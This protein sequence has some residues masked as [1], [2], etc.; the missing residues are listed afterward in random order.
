MD[1]ARF[2]QRGKDHEL[3]NEAAQRRN[4]HQAEQAD[5]HANTQHRR[6]AGEPVVVFD[7]F[8]E[9]QIAQ[10][11]DNGKGA[12]VH[13]QIDQQVV[14]Q[15]LQ[16]PLPLEAWVD[17][18]IRRGI[19]DNQQGRNSHQHITGVG[20]RGIGQKAFHIRLRIGGQVAIRGGYRGDNAKSHAKGEIDV[21]ERPAR[22]TDEGQ[23]EA[24]QQREG[25]S[26]RC[27][28]QET[29]HF[30]RRAFKGVRT[31][32]MERDQRQLERQTGQH[33]HDPQHNGAYHRVRQTRSRPDHQ[34]QPRR[35]LGQFGR[36]K[37]A[38]Q[39]ADPVQHHASRS[40]AVDNVLERRL[41]AET[42]ALQKTDQDV[43]GHTRH[44]DAQEQDQ[45]VVRTDHQRHPHHRSQQ[46]RVEIGAV[47]RIGN[48]A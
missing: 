20:N 5:G 17:G 21:R 10:D 47:I 11:G 9:D 25:G 39:Q 48:T 29:G 36:S 35:Q 13:K 38:G 26:L 45:K 31:P 32:E 18:R 40:A 6:L 19:R 34:I 33:H 7:F 15:P 1:L 28:G 2:E 46:Q 41:A 44:L 4:A 8:T 22:V 12:K 27:H 23:T 43:A 3:P 16:A 14:Q 37:H 30:G 24:N 42:P